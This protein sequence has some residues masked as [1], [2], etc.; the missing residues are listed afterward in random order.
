MILPL[1]ET[2]HGRNLFRPY[3]VEQAENNAHS[4]LLTSF[5]TQNSPGPNIPDRK[6]ADN[7]LNPLY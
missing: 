6:A 4:F 2:R 5:R 1:Q 7:D 3:L